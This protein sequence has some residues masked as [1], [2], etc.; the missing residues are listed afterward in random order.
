MVL[1][2]VAVSGA[3]IALAGCAQYDEMRSANLAAAQ[4]ER[5]ATEEAACRENGVQPGSQAYADCRKEMLRQRQKSAYR[6]EEV[7][8]DMLNE[9]HLRPYGE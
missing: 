3:M 7:A 5:V 1:R 4:Q 6:Q 2:F 8:R 9:S